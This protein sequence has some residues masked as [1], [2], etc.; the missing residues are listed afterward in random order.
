MEVTNGFI[1]LDPVIIKMHNAPFY[2]FP[3]PL[4]FQLSI[5]LFLLPL[6]QIEDFHLFKENQNM[7]KK[8]DRM[9]LMEIQYL[10][11]QLG[12]EGGDINAIRHAV[13]SQ[14]SR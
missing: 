10:A 14:S 5:L 6:I 7:I 13:V 4:V 9:I 11:Q 3:T 12:I 8:G 1:T 2:K